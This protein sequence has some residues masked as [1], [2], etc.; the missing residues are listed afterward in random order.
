MSEGGL[1]LR[2]YRAI[3]LLVV[4]GIAIDPEEVLELLREGAVAG[5]VLVRRHGEA[6]EVT[7]FVGKGGWRRR[8]E[9]GRHRKGV[10]A[11]TRAATRGL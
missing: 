11:G 7:F 6:R 9:D 10:A 2:L 3:S 1:A 5:G 8:V 4:A